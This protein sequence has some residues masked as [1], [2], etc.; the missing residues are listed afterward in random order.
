MRLFP[1]VSCRTGRRSTD[2]ASLIAR[3]AAT[4]TV[5]LTLDVH[6]RV[7]IIKS[8][9]KGMH[10]RDDVEIM[11]PLIDAVLLPAIW[12]AIYPMD[13]RN[14]FAA[15]DAINVVAREFARIS[16]G[17]WPPANTSLVPRE[18]R[19]AGLIFDY[20]PLIHRDTRLAG[21]GGSANHRNNSRCPRLYMKGAGRRFGAH[22][23]Q[24]ISNGTISSTD[25]ASIWRWAGGTAIR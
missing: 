7:R 6:G 15:A 8:V 5:P 2:R 17:P 18:Q 4:A 9:S 21:W 12:A 23:H 20:V 19:P 10:V 1:D 13:T 16:P 3:I 25:L 14:D 22:W 24:V 11:C